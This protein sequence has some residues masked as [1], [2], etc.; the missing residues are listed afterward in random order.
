MNEKDRLIRA[1]LIIL[2]LAAEIK[3]VARACKLAGVSRSQFYLIKKAYAIYG[4]EGLAPRSRRKPEMP[5][6]TPAPLEE[7][8]LIH[9]RKYPLLSYVRL[10]GEIKSKA[11]GV[12]PTM[13]R[14]VWRRHALSTRLAR[15]EW[16]GLSNGSVSIRSVQVPN[17]R[18]LRGRETT[19]LSQTRRQE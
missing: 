7:E 11:G 16:A 9:T 3:N 1:Q 10:A 17:T 6:Q 5:N 18:L 13:V 8:I 15:L 2:T 4:R 14:Y 19:N 12:T